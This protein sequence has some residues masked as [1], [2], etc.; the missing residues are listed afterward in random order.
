LVHST[1]IHPATAIHCFKN[2]CRYE[3]LIAKI[4]RFYITLGSIPDLIE[5]AK[6]YTEEDPNQDLDDEFG[7]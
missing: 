7:A 5:I 2:A 4:K 1:G 3:P 6:R